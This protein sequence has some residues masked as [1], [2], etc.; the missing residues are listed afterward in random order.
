MYIRNIDNI[1]C[2]IKKQVNDV[3][4]CKHCSAQTLLSDTFVSVSNVR[5]LVSPRTVQAHCEK[6]AEYVVISEQAP[7]LAYLRQA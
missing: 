6:Y 2:N 5:I 4:E 3:K 1:F 7:D